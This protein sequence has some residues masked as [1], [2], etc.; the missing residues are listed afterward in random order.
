MEMIMLKALKF[1]ALALAPLAWSPSPASAQRQQVGFLN[2]DI[3]MG[4]GMIIGSQRQVSCLFDPAD[5]TPREVYVGSITKFGLDLG[6]TTGGHMT[7]AVH[8]ETTRRSGVLEGAYAGASA[9][10]TLGVGLGAN[11]LIGG[12]NRTI[13]LQPLSV[14]GQTGLNVAAGVAELR[15]QLAR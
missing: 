6:I 7:W 11:V 2:C 3:S 5:G 15:L 10:A 8:S 9:E 1:C 12:S 13:A 4:I 14:Q